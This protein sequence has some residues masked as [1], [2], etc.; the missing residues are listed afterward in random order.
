MKGRIISIVSAL[1]LMSA[2]GRA[3]VEPTERSERTVPADA[4][5]EEVSRASAFA[6][7]IL[8]IE[9]ETEGWADGGVVPS[10]SIF[11]PAFAFCVPSLAV[12]SVGNLSVAWYDVVQHA[13]G[14]YLWE[15]TVIARRTAEQGGDTGDIR[16]RYNAVIERWWKDKDK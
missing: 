3:R 13:W 5:V 11:D 8:P 16:R 9:D 6:S 12:S 1:A 2:F 15:L 7:G 4:A 10:V 14:S